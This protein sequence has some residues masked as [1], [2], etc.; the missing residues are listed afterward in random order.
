M[1]SLL[2]MGM[3]VYY[4]RNGWVQHVGCHKRKFESEVLKKFSMLLGPNAN[5]VV[6]PTILAKFGY[7]KQLDKDL[8]VRLTGSLY[9]NANLGNSNLYSS[10]RSG[11]GFGVF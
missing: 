10:S 3:E 2:K 11:F 1:H 6:S 8:R 4:N 7:D 9:H 5:T